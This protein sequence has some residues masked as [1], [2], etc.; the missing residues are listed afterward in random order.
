MILEA[1]KDTPVKGLPLGNGPG[2]AGLQKLEGQPKAPIPLRGRICR[3]KGDATETPMGCSDIPI[4]VVATSWAYH[5]QGLG[6]SLI[7]P[8]TG[9]ASVPAGTHPSRPSPRLLPLLDNLP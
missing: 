1:L 7:W 9:H 3:G 5:R 6:A 2:F 8:A 4:P